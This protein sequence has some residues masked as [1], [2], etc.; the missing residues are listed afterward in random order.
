M[1]S[2]VKAVLRLLALGRRV[3][4]YGG[5]ARSLELT[6]QQVIAKTENCVVQKWT[7]LPLDE[8]KKEVKR[9]LRKVQGWFGRG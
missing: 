5:S 1:L 4:S 3:A 7:K 8:Q 2:S 9:Q 6:V